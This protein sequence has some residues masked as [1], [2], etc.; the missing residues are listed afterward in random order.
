MGALSLPSLDLFL[1]RKGDPMS[2]PQTANDLSNF[3][4]ATIQDGRE[5]SVVM[6]RRQ[7][8]IRNRLPYSLRQAMDTYSATAEAILAGGASTPRDTLAGGCQGGAPARE[9]RQAV[10]LDQVRFLRRIEDAVAKDTI[11]VGKSDPVLV[12]AL[13]LWRAVCLGGATMQSFLARRGLKPAK[14]RM[15]ALNQGFEAAAT[16]A[17]DAIGGTRN[18]Y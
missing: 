1:V 3:E 2:N 8:P 5:V 11:T 12:P 15:E 9:G 10:A 18:P 7:P 14:S 16:R 6:R 13:D 4:A 17:A